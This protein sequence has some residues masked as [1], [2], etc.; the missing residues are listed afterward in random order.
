MCIQ[1]VNDEHRQ[2]KFTLVVYERR[3][4]LLHMHQSPAVLSTRQQRLLIT[5]HG[6]LYAE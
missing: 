1:Q 6:A 4:A 2:L 5:A 3:Y